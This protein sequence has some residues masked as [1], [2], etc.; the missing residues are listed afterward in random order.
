MARAGKI[1][2]D[3]DLFPEPVRREVLPLFEDA[4]ASDGRIAEIMLGCAAEDT[5]IHMS[6][7]LAAGGRRSGAFAPEALLV[8]RTITAQQILDQLVG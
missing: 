2:Y 4:V 7:T 3:D 1:A 8:E 6:A 5:L